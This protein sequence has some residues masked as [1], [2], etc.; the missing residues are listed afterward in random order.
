MPKHHRKK[1]FQDD[2]KVLV[3]DTIALRLWDFAQ[4]DP[5][6]CTGLRLCHRG[7]CQ[8]MNPHRKAKGLTLSATADTYV[9]PSDATMIQEIGISLIDCSWEQLDSVKHIIKD[10]SHSRKLPFMVAANPVK[11]GKPY[12]LTCAEAAAA[13]LIIC[14]YQ[15]EGELLLKEFAWGDEFL[16]INATVLELYQ[17]CASSHEVQAAQDNFLTT[18]HNEQVAFKQHQL[19][20][21]H[22]SQYCSAVDLP[23]SD[24]ESYYEDEEDEPELDSFGNY[25]NASGAQL[26]K[27]NND[28][29]DE[30]ETAEEE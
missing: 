3:N 6:R 19:E 15:T 10:D 26:L 14:G 21:T 1:Q 25:V 16:K 13:C 30:L 11:Y 20:N 28:D 12:T 9:S 17:N 27:P 29:E 4:C 7:L 22:S 18:V 23:P 5:K 24:D 8:K 2:K